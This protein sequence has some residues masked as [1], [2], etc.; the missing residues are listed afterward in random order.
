MHLCKL[1]ANEWAKY[2]IRINA[3]APG[4]TATEGI[5]RL[6]NYLPVWKE[7]IPMGRLMKPSEIADAILFLASEEASAITG[8]QLLVD[9][10]YSTW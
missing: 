2:N 1:L 9:G 4:Y 6:M 8:T 7:K 10:G 5:S 3:V